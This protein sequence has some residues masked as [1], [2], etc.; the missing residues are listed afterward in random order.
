MG[1]VMEKA[2]S[3]EELLRELSEMASL[4]EFLEAA[5]TERSE[6]ERKLLESERKYRHL[7]ENLLDAAF[8]ADI[9][10]GRIIETNRKAEE[11][12]GRDRSEI[13][14]MHQSELHP[15]EKR[16]EYKKKF[17]EHVL[18]GSATDY[19]ADAVR[20]D[21]TIIPVH[22]SA[23]V[24][25]LNKQT[26]IFGIFKD[27][28]ERKKSEEALK[29][30]KE[31]S[32][33]LIKLLKDGFSVIGIDKVLKEVNPALCRMTGF[34]RDELVGSM[35]PYPYWPEEYH[36]ELLDMLDR[37]VK[38]DTNDF[39]V[40]FKRK[41]GEQFHAILSPSILRDGKGNTVCYF[42]T[43]KDITERKKME[44][45]LLKAQ[46]LES[47]S[48]LAGGIAHDFNNML[49]AVLSNI[50]LAKVYKGA[51]EMDSW[52]TD[53]EKATFRAKDLAERL[54]T[55]A[56]GGQPVKKTIDTGELLK[57]S[58]GFALIGTHVACEYE[59]Q[60]G[61]W[62]IEADE[63][64][65]NQVIHNI[66]L[67]G[68]Q[69]MPEGGTI[70]VKAENIRPALDDHSSRGR[71]L[72]KVSIEDKG[73][74]IPEENLKKAFDPFFTTKEQGSGLGLSTAYSIVKNH[75]GFIDVKSQVGVGTIF[76]I[77]LPASGRRV[78]KKRLPEETGFIFDGRVLIMDDEKP[79]RDIACVILSRSGCSVQVASE[80]KEA[81][82][83]YIK[84]KEEG[85]PFDAVIMDL[86][87]PGGMGGME[88]AKR[89]LE[90]DPSAK[91]IV[92]SG[93]SNDP[94]MSDFRRYGFAGII[95]K[96]YRLWDLAKIVRSVIQGEGQAA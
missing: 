19:N 33:S 28:T 78:S 14:G 49:T 76:D 93:Y 44:D 77:Y 2:K 91:I 87:V 50:S 5:D 83:F 73:V 10:T 23:A 62:P 51:D 65:I 38:G 37:R 27:I 69:A 89:L 45:E 86:T 7:F 16:E 24:I 13:I 6:F 63:A 48:I 82:E 81:V 31:F 94:V 12:L 39:E 57:E 26:A 21:G 84:A 52:L 32:E 18:F 95:M 47:L 11:L 1:E 9:E 17:S 74:G 64:Q 56:T 66:V 58:A 59:I 30:S 67:N 42:A 8:V 4:V 41:S 29:A 46:K 96:P 22:I 70:R 53:A 3:R 80:G 40:I 15:P 20:K 88:A 71:R 72:I 90:F 61:I 34:S 92:S 55:F 36:K 43:I 60:E 54:L 85:H 68:V 35:P 25:K 75:G 79:L